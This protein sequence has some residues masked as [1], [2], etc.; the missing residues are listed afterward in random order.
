MILSLSYLNQKIYILV[1]KE[2]SNIGIDI[3]GAHLKIVG[4]NNND[5]VIYVKYTSCKKYGKILRI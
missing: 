2:I 5:Q 4:L 1:D 3:G